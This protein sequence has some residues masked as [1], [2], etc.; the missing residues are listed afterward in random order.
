MNRAFFLKKE[1]RDPKWIVID[2][3]DKVLGRLATEVADILR[4]KNKPSFTAHTD[5]G[6]YVVIINAEKIKLTGNKLEDKEYVSY[7]GWIGGQKTINAKD[8]MQKHPEKV[9]TFAVKG[10][11]PK[12]KLADQII[13]KLKIYNGKEHPHKAQISK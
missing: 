5:G 4:G 1:A 3:E 8:L 13:K 12:N 2:A 6:D 11:L 7:S 10:M 9:I